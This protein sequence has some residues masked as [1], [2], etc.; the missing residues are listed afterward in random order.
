M[1]ITFERLPQ[2]EWEHAFGVLTDVFA[3]EQHIPV[4]LIA[5][6]ATFN[7]IWWCAKSDTEIVGIAASWKVRI[8]PEKSSTIV[9][10]I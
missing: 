6:A 10:S 5:I 7:P 9:Q 2:S 1:E 3:G 4:E 8:N